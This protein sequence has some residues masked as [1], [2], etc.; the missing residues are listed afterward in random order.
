MLSGMTT[1]ISDKVSAVKY[2]ELYFGG[3][4]KRA[5]GL[6]KVH[7]V[8]KIKA[9]IASERNALFVP[10]SCQTFVKA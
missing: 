8:I 4:I 7:K 10:R 5:S 2:G 3:K 6:D 1:R 9:R